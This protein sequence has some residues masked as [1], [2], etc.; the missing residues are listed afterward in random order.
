MDMVLTFTVTPDDVEFS[1]GSGW[2]YSERNSEIGRT[3]VQKIFQE[4]HVI[5]YE[6]RTYHSAVGGE[7]IVSFV[8]KS[9]TYE[10]D[11][12]PI[13]GPEPSINPPKL[14]FEDLV[15]EKIS[16]IKKWCESEIIKGIDI[17]FT[18]STLETPGI[19]HY[20]LTKYH[21]EDLWIRWLS[22]LNDPELQQISWRDE[23]RVTH[24]LYTVEE[25]L[26]LFRAAQ[27]HIFRCKFKSDVLEQKILS[28]DE[29]QSELVSALT[30]QTPLSSEENEQVDKFVKLL[31]KQFELI[32]R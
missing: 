20:T 30:W 13:W 2:R 25:F 16:E 9:A 31:M 6:S 17:D 29:S 18:N 28:Y 3:A 22:I 21:Q 23:A 7:E 1:D 12:L 5:K 11:I 10:D 32:E 8:A 19:K 15:N 27:E 24:E 26:K 14:L 4:N